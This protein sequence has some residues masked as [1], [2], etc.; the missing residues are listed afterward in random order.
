MHARKKLILATLGVFLAGLCGLGIHRSITAPRPILFAATDCPT[1][2]TDKA[3]ITI[4]VFED[5]GCPSCHRFI[6]EILPQIQAAYIERGIAKLVLIPVVLHWESKTMANAILEV[7]RQAPEKVFPFLH[8]LIVEFR[9]HNPSVL[10]LIDLAKR[11]GIIHLEDFANHIETGRYHQELAGNLRLA[12]KTMKKN[13]KTPALYINGFS[14]PALSFD[15]IS[16][17]INRILHESRP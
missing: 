9:D 16:M 12:K 6:L 2:G 8:D 5:L 14:T 13:L 15:T 3:Q 4:I 17:Q 10:D 11:M 7:H 1:A